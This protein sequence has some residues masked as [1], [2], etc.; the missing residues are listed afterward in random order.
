[1]NFEKVRELAIQTIVARPNAQFSFEDD[2]KD[3]VITKDQMLDT[4]RTGI[5][6]LAGDFKSYR[7]NKLLVFELIEE[8]ADLY[9]PAK[10][11]QN[12]GRFA[13][14]KDGNIGDKPKF[15]MVLGK[16]RGK[17]FVTRVG[18]SGIYE[19]FRL[20]SSEFGVET[21]RIG[22]A[23][24]IS[25]ERLLLGA[26]DLTDI[27]DV[28]LEGIEDSVYGAVQT[29]LQASLASGAQA[30]N[31]GENAGFSATIL[32]GLVNSISAYGKPIIYCTPEFA[33]TIVPDTGYV[34]DADK[35]DKRELGYIGKWNGIE[36]VV[37]PQSWVD[38]TNAVKVFD[39]QLAYIIPAGRE[40]IVKVLFEGQTVVEEVTNRNGT[41]EISA[42]KRM[43]VAVLFN[44]QFAIMKNSSL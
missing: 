13:E 20:D 6:E 26:E 35:S 38:E 25:L 15:K 19:V 2:G 42:T 31:Y 44:N 10:V 36:I 43:G 32:Q 17:Q 21:E 14:V 34:G 7:R 37:M 24:V 16:N 12:I 22:G 41:R 4:L 30:S 11:K 28:I 9:L 3:V 18:T 5:N 29:A 33:Q 39:P 1:M 23:G 40:K 27:L 8:T